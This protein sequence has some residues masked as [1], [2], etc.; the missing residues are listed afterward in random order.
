MT[1]VMR[2]TIHCGSWPSPE[3]LLIPFLSCSAV[4]QRLSGLTC[5][6]LGDDDYY[7]A[8]DYCETLACSRDVFNLVAEACPHLRCLCLYRTAELL[9]VWDIEPIFRLQHMEELQMELPPHVEDPPP[10]RSGERVLQ[11]AAHSRIRRI[12]LHHYMYEERGHSQTTFE[13]F[14][15]A[16]A[17]LPELRQLTLLDQGAAGHGNYGGYRGWGGSPSYRGGGFDAMT[18]GVLGVEHL[19]CLQHLTSL[20]WNYVGPAAREPAPS[21]TAG[22]GPLGVAVPRLQ[23]QSA[24]RAISCLG[25]LAALDLRSYGIRDYACIRLLA[26]MPSLRTVD[27][28]ALRP[29]EKMV[30]CRCAWERLSL[31]EASH[32][33]LARLPLSGVL[34]IDLQR[35]FNCR[36]GPGGSAEAI[37]S[38]AAELSAAAEVLA[39]TSPRDKSLELEVSW[40]ELVTLPREGAKAISAALEPL[41]GLVRS[42]KLCNCLL[43]D[44]SVLRLAETLPLVQHLALDGVQ[45]RR[46]HS[47]GSFAWRFNHL[48]RLIITR[49]PLSFVE[50]GEARSENM[51]AVEKGGEEEGGPSRPLAVFITEHGVAELAAGVDKYDSQGPAAGL[52]P[53]PAGTDSLGV[54]AEKYYSF[55]LTDLRGGSGAEDF[56]PSPYIQNEHRFV[57]RIIHMF[58]AYAIQH[59][60]NAVSKQLTAPA[61]E[62]GRLPERAPGEHNTGT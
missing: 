1:I 32:Q 49:S 42:L 11:L 31:V 38:A 61:L 9:S 35:P 29:S 15:P 43:D 24:I 57:F 27:V 34:H 53:Q 52:S 44:R 25:Q 26:E 58:R 5:L 17:R 19:N 20:S 22:G 59:G 30:C 50:A 7:E 4:A 18:T 51:R 33:D 2:D 60:W 46:I 21:T 13:A 28:W 16:L 10:N 40:D 47:W 55:F 23:L 41:G 39:R 12:L 54:A 3:E 8:A 36:L 48:V 14:L 56:P 62:E 6:Q 45:L 37:F